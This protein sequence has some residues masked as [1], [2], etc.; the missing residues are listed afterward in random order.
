MKAEGGRWGDRRIGR[1]DDL[2]FV[3]GVQIHNPGNWRRD[4]RL[5]LAQGGYGILVL[6]WLFLL[7]WVGMN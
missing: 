5:G 7:V 1:G 4:Q 6:F 2:C 3:E